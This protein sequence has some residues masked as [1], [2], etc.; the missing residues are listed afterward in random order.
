MSHTN[1]IAS[2]QTLAHLNLNTLTTERARRAY[3]VAVA[4]TMQT[5]PNHF[6][7]IIK[8]EVAAIESMPRAQTLKYENAIY[9]ATLK[10]ALFNA[11]RCYH[12]MLDLVA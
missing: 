10:C 3:I 2:I 8:N 4:K 7:E 12:A 11:R 9:L 1:Y 5:T 6:I